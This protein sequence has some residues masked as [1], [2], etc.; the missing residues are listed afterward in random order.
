MPTLNY[1][2]L[3]YFWMVA[4]SGSIARACK[5]LHLTPQ[6]ISGQ[7]RELEQT[8]GVELFHRIGRGLEVTDAGRR[9]L[10]YA[11][12]IFALG[13]EL[14]DIARDQT[15]RRSL[16]FAVGIADSVAKMVA[17]RLIEP[18]LSLPEAVRLI[19]R[20]GRLTPLLAEL[21]VHRLD[22]VIADQPMPANLNVRGFSH[23]LTESEL[24]VFGADAL[25]AK[26]DGDF[27]ALL[28]GAPFLLPGDDVA[29]RT[30]LE[31]WFASQ[32]LHPRIVGEFDDSAL[33]K[34]FAQGGAGL[35]AAPSAIAGHL[36]EQYRVR[37][38]G[39][40]ETISE[41]VYAITTERRSSHPATVAIIEQA[42]SSAIG[43]ARRGRRTTSEVGRAL[44][45]GALTALPQSTSSAGDSISS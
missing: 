38:L 3:R 30:R 6:A 34:A 20:E 41:Q 40:I 45:G 7:L 43:S 19:C 31:E 14:L 25:L 36:T 33:L 1:K 29:I 37:A 44:P 16:P 22:I 24:S 15:T 9:I 5:Q 17:H 18:V 32:R 42:R 11:D 27:P 23:L 4:K 39:R 28:Q 2:H 26:L 13:D 35:F 12:E 8:L 21:A 10:S